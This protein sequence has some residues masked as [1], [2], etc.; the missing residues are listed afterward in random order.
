MSFLPTLFPQEI[1]SEELLKNDSSLPILFI[2]PFS[3]LF[4]S[5]Q[6]L[7]TSFAMLSL[8]WSPPPDEFHV[9]IGVS[10]C[11][12]CSLQWLMYSLILSQVIK[13]FPIETDIYWQG[14][15]S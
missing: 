9:E 3:S 4:S 13:P 11:I 14:K 7:L 6:N 12:S 10:H 15:T 1:G 5:R 8:F 2:L